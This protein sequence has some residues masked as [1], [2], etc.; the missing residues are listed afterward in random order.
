MCVKIAI[1]GAGRI[2]KVHARAVSTCPDAEL[3][4]VFDPIP[5]FANEIAGQ[6]QCKVT[7]IN[8]IANDSSIHAVLICTPT[9]THAELIEKFAASGKAIFCEKPI[10]LDLQRVLSCLEVVEQNDAKLMVG[11]NR[12][13]DV[14]FHGVKQTLRSGELGN[15]EQVIITSR[16][17]A[18]PPAEYIKV[19]GGIFRDMMIHDFDMARFLLGEEPKYV[20][21]MGSVLVD[22]VMKKFGDFD[23]A[24]A[25]LETESGKLCVIS[26][27]RRASYGY[28]QRVEVHCANGSIVAEN[29]RPISTEIATKSGFTRP[30]LHDFFMTRYEQAYAD[31]IISFVDCVKN[32]T[33]PTPNGQDGLLALKL[34][35]AAAKSITNQ[36]RVNL[37]E[38][39]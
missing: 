23:S 11:F 35:D 17:P 27:S 39:L 7:S 24:V 34:A 21:A 32:N 33:T 31:E 12:R 22:P 29:Q 20:N 3:V 30:P 9:D 26:N 19:S 14:H 4:A 37:D 13:F 36:R 25:T 28:D 15:I 8:E 38:L 6:Y 16:D 18:P 1:L 10:H 2:G 5:D